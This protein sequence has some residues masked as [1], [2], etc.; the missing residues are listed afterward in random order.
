MAT[1]RFHSFL[2]QSFAGFSLWD[3]ICVLRSS[4]KQ[5]KIYWGDRGRVTGKEGGGGTG[6]VGKLQTRAKRAKRG[7]G[8]EEAAA[9]A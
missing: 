8:K 6:W 2:F 1:T 9:A 3:P 5:A 7:I 4:K